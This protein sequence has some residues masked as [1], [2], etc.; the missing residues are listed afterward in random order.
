MNPRTTL[1]MG[2]VLV[3]VLATLAVLKIVHA[4]TESELAARRDRVIPALYDVDPDDVTRV[5]LKREGETIA[6]DRSEASER[7]Q[8]TQ[9]AKVLADNSRVRDVISDLKNLSR[10]TAGSAKDD[11]QGAFTPQDKSYL[12]EYR[13]DQ[14]LKTVTLTYRPKGADKETKS[15]TLD[16]GTTT[17][18]NEGLYVKLASEPVVFVVNKTSLNSLDKKANEFRQPKLV[19][20]GRFDADRLTLEWPERKIVAEKKDSKWHLAEPIEDRADQNKVEDL[21]AK[22][23]DLKAE[24]DSGFVDDNATDPAKY[25]LDQPRLIAAIHKPGS[26]PSA[27]DQNKNKKDKAKEKAELTEKVLIGKEVEGQEGKLYAKLAD[28]N[29]VIAVS[30]ATVA[31]LDKQPNDLRSRDLVDLAPNSDV[32]YVAIQRSDAKIVLAKKGFD[33]ELYEPKKA[34]AE[35]TPVNDLIKKIDDLEIKEFFDNADLKEYGLDDPAV[36]V[37]L[38]KK[39]LQGED[40]TATRQDEAK[41]AETKQGEK[42]AEAAPEPKGSPV[43]LWFGKRDE[44]KKL[45]YVKRG[46]SGSVVAVTD[47]GLWELLDRGYLAYRRK[48]VLAFSEPDAAKISIYRDGKTYSVERKEEKEGELKKETWR[49]TEPVDAPADSTTVSDLLFGLSRLNAT[50]LV[51]ETPSDLQPYGLDE[52][53]IRA[54]I[55]LKAEGDKPPVQHVLLIGSPV[56]PDEGSHARLGDGDLVFVVDTR[57]VNLLESELRD[58]T[59]LKFDAGKADTLSLT[60]ADGGKLELANQKPAGKPLKEWTVTGGSELKPDTGKVRDLVSF[61]AN[62]RADRFAQYTGDLKPEYGME[63]PALTIEVK[64]E[65]ESTPKTLRVGAA[66]EGDKRYVA[67]DASGAVGLIDESRVKDLLTG[68]PHFAVPEEKKPEE[69][70]PETGEKTESPSEPAEKKET[71]P[72]PQQKKEATPAAPEKKQPPQASDQPPEKKDTPNASSKSDNV[73]KDAKPKSQP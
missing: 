51:A 27:A 45:T 25:G 44:E 35:S 24:G 1:V 31:E 53:R 68:P 7:W 11:K 12:A 43:E 17:A 39:G 36:R 21:I 72:A 22:L 3:A 63:Q 33:W 38:Y 54:T 18:D 70:K 50:R 20:I 23:G 28:Q 2:G 13:L 29:Y 19:S 49:M 66:A 71:P 10:R 5:E 59:V 16:V 60:W 41:A 58:H 42:K 64:V 67:S 34:P 52:P 56:E 73:K 40:G 15:V 61:L 69:K 46:D 37:T 57:T 55:T 26:E 4:P 65:S 30:A 14:P 6:L 9:P 48:Q 47:E 8:M 32:D 62:L